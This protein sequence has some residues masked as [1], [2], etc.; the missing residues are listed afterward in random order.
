MKYVVKATCRIKRH[1]KTKASQ[2]LWLVIPQSACSVD[3]PGSQILNLCNSCVSS[4]FIYF[5]PSSV[6]FIVFEMRDRSGTISRFGGDGGG[7]LF[8]P[9]SCQRAWSYRGVVG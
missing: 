5:P 6:S 1:S 4:V 8:G 2:I 3:L 9:V 7:L